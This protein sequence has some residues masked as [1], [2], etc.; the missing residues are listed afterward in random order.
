MHNQCAEESET[1]ILCT[2]SAGRQCKVQVVAALVIRDAVGDAISRQQAAVKPGP[3]PGRRAAGEALS[4]ASSVLGGHVHERRALRL[5]ALTWAPFTST[6]G[7]LRQVYLYLRP[8]RPALPLPAPPPSGPIEQQ[9]HTR[10][11]RELS[12]GLP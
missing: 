3:W 11:A 9:A 6:S 8:P 5:P 12:L 4:R 2:G 7:G 1:L 10:Q